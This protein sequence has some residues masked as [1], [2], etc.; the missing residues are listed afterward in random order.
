MAVATCEPSRAWVLFDLVL[1]A[2]ALEN[3]LGASHPENKNRPD[4]VFLLP[5]PCKPALSLFDLTGVVATPSCRVS[6]FLCKTLRTAKL[7][8]TL[9]SPQRA[10]AGLPI[11][12]P[13]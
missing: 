8:I 1:P 11:A 10:W 6:S 13:I 5:V 12:L 2:I 4:A 3:A 9:Q 7:T